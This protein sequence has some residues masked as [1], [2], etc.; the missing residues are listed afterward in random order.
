[1]TPFLVDAS[2]AIK[3]LLPAG[4]EPDTD[5]ARWLI[6]EAELKTTTLAHYEVASTIQ[7]IHPAGGAAAVEACA[8]LRAICGEP[9]PLLPD[10][11]IAAAAIAD[12]HGLTFYDASYAAIALG[13]GWSLISVDRDLLRPGLA[14][15]VPPAGSSAPA[16]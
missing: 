16:P 5:D 9:E 14:A 4:R 15:P 8:L 2:V 12:E 13:R 7:R 11:V 1:M 3:W 10:D 6:G